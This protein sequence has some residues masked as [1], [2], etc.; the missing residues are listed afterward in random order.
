M[1][2]DIQTFARRL[3]QQG[4]I[5]KIGKARKRTLI[6]LGESPPD[7]KRFTQEAQGQLAEEFRIP[8]HLFFG[9]HDRVI[10]P[11]TGHNLRKFAPDRITQEELPAGHILLTP[12][13]G[14]AI[15]A[16]LDMAPLPTA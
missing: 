11:T 9:T 16:H 2:N 1:L 3:L 7:A 15:I 4:T 10:P 8:I 14:S 5:D 12:E 6:A 13:L